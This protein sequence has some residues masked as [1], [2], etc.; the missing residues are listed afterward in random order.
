MITSGWAY[1]T[2]FTIRCCCTNVL[3]L[4][5]LDDIFVYNN[6]YW[7]VLQCF[8]KGCARGQRQRHDYTAQSPAFSKA[9]VSIDP[10]F[11]CEKNSL[12]LKKKPNHFFNKTV[13]VLLSKK[14]LDN[15][16]VLTLTAHCGLWSIMHNG[17]RYV[18]YRVFYTMILVFGIDL[19][20]K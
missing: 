11:C 12:K 14:T 6:Y 19:M 8:L 5:S 2:L 18:A 15:V 9:P 13:F 7:R 3:T 1:N 10:R 4:R 16:I 17:W 20:P